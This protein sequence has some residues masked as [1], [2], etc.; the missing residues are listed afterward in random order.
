MC[1]G[2]WLAADSTTLYVGEWLAA[3]ITTL[4]VAVCFLFFDSRTKMVF[5][6]HVT[7]C[8]N[9]AI[10]IVSY[11]SKAY[12]RTSVNNTIM[13]EYESKMATAKLEINNQ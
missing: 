11:T 10:L 3:D 13:G 5:N 7:I 2:E 1:V 8:Q 6:S 12:H 9:V 4:C